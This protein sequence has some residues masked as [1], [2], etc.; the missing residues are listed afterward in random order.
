MKS[1][2]VDYFSTKR[3]YDYWFL[4]TNSWWIKRDARRFLRAIDLDAMKQVQAN[5]ATQTRDKNPWVRFLI[6]ED[7]LHRECFRARRYGMHRTEHGKLR[8]LDVGTGPGYYLFVCSQ[9]GHEVIGVDLDVPLMDRVA[10]VLGVDRR[11]WPI[12]RDWPPVPFSGKFNMI[13]AFQIGFD[14][15]IGPEPDP[16][17]AAD[18]KRFLDFMISNHLEEGGRFVL[19]G[20]RSCLKE[21]E[22]FDPEVVAMLRS[23]GAKVDRGRIE[24]ASWRC[25]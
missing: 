9:F 25:D 5:Y 13:T 18:W 7:N 21:S 8:L 16:W 24:I 14:G 23:H 15:T 20:V 4:L 1:W 17:N 19:T 12:D 6:P 10:N 2:L 3:P 22:Y 11:V